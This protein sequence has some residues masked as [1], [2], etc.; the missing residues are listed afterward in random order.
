MSVHDVTNKS[1][2]RDS[3]NIVDVVMSPK[4]SNSNISR[5]EIILTPIL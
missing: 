1:L 4:L 2:S 5:K 3:N